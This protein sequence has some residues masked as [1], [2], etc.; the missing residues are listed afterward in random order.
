[1]G[2]LNFKNGTLKIK[3]GPNEPFT[4]FKFLTSFETSRQ[5]DTDTISTSTRTVQ[6]GDNSTGAEIKMENIELPDNKEH[7]RLQHRIV[8][9]GKSGFY[10]AIY[11][12][13][14]NTDNYN[15][16]GTQDVHQSWL[17][18]N[19]TFIA[20]DSWS[21]SDQMTRSA[22]IKASELLKNVDGYDGSGSYEKAKNG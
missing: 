20:D 15:N 12:G 8:T 14:A 22:T 21:P 1:M 10:E 6:V 2:V 11:E 4:E 7:A 18:R 9:Q 17:M 3:L 13:D 16:D 19:G 5:D